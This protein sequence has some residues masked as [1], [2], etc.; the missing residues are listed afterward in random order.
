MDIAS[1]YNTADGI[2]IV[3][4]SGH[5]VF[6]WTITTNYRSFA[7]TFLMVNSRLAGKTI[8]D[9]QEIHDIHTSTGIIIASVS[10]GDHVFIKF[11]SYS[12]GNI[13][14]HYGQNAFSGWKL[15]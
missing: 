12:S 2:F 8:A 3:P 9:A 4:E 13:T 7:T 6:T 11:G 14:N 10:Q 15:Y 5:Y 1:A